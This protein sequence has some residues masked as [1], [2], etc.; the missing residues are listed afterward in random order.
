MTFSEFQNIAASR[1]LQAKH[2]NHG[3]HW[4]L[5]G[6]PYTVNY[7]PSKGRIYLNGYSHGIPGGSQRALKLA[8]TGV[9]TDNLV[10]NPVKRKKS[11]KKTKRRL[12]RANPTCYWCGEELTIETATVDHLI[13]LGKG[14]SNG[15]DN[16]RLAC[17]SCNQ[18][19]QDDLPH[20]HKT[21]VWRT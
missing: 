16:L 7:Y 9:E 8:F 17:D 3:H 10:N 12:W 13:P 15:T 21:A 2:L 19:R 18:D 1:G 14:G 11:Y 5:K 6:G 4:Q 20:Q